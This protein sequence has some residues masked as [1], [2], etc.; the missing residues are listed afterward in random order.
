MSSGENLENSDAL[1][2]IKYVSGK[3]ETHSEIPK[4]N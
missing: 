4:T 3:H 1:G 2:K